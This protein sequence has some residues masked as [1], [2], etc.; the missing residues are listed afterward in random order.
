MSNQGNKSVPP[1][2]KKQNIVRVGGA[3]NGQEQLSQQQLAE[4]RS[5]RNPYKNLTSGSTS[6]QTKP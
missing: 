2:N 6:N 1:N 4:F 3:A 5:N